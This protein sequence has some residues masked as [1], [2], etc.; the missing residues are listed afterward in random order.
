MTAAISSEYEVR[1]EVIHGAPISR[2]S[3]CNLQ[4]AIYNKKCTQNE[5]KPQNKESN[6]YSFMSALLLTA[7]FFPLISALLLP[8]DRE[9]SRLRALFS[10]LLT[11]VVAAVLIYYYPGGTEPFAK[12]DV[13]WFGSASADELNPNYPSA[14]TDH[15]GSLVTSG[16]PIDIRFSIALDGLSIWLFGLTALLM[17]TAVLVGWEAISEQA[18]L[19]YRMLLILETGMLG[20][21]VARD[22][23]LF[24]VF[25]EFTLIPLFFIIGI[26]GST[27]RRY[28]AIKFFLFTLAGSVLTFLRR[29]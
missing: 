7:V 10:V 3:G 26:W 9:Q 18:S 24:Y 20:V 6:S 29:L 15:A 27:Q 5:L 19:Y 21:F 17:L 23:I 4:F 25:F 28:A 13:S 2:S 16:T 22:I 11:F 14:A 8:K 12:T 1:R